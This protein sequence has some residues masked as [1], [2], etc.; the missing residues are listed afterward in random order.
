MLWWLGLTYI[1]TKMKDR[2]GETGI[3]YLN[4]T[5]GV[6]VIFASI[7]YALM[8]LCTLSSFGLS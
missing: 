8:T 4:R 1:I 2:F 6:I 3:L 5:I 7:I